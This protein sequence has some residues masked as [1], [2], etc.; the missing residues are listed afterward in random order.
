[1][2]T[3]AAG[4]EDTTAEDHDPAG[5]GGDGTGRATASTDAEARGRRRS[6]RPVVPA[7]TLRAM[8]VSAA[9]LTLAAVAWLTSWVLL[10]LPLVTFTLAVALLVAALMAPVS[11][12]LRRAGLPAAPSAL[13]AVL[14]LVAVLG[15]IGFLFGFRVASA[16]QDLSRPLAAGVDRIRVWAIEGPLHLDPQQVSDIRNQI[17]NWIYEAAPSPTAGARMAVS[18][19]GALLLVAFLVFF[20]LKDGDTMWSWLLERVP[21]RRHDQV[22]GAGRAA[23]DTLAHYVRGAVLVAL[24]DAVGIGVGLLVLGVPLWLSLTLLTFVGAFI[25]VLGATV[26]GAVAVLVTLVTNDLTD[27]VVVLVIVLVVQQVEGNLLQPLIMGRALHLHPAVILVAVT[28]GGLLLGIP[29]ALLAVPVLAVAYR[30]LEYVR[31]HPVRPGGP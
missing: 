16:M 6:G 5:P 27:A 3:G 31:L 13:L 24:V 28:S 20:F 9:V 15:G 4:T 26:S 25:P 11:G 18:L 29:G 14:S 10:R 17:V 8:A 12:A 7:W 21:E 30:V 1:M 22:D 2:H 19:L 23:W